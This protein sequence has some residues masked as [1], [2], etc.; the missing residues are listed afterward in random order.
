MN[1]AD[2]F[3]LDLKIDFRSALL[4]DY[5]LLEPDDPKLRQFGI[6]GNPRKILT[7][8][9]LHAQSKLGLDI[10]SAIVFYK[11]ANWRMDVAHVDV[12]KQ[13]PNGAVVCAINWIIG[14][15]GSNMIWYDK[16]NDARGD[17]V[18]DDMHLIPRAVYDVKNLIELHRA[19]VGNGKLTLVRTNIPHTIECGP[20][21][22]WCISMRA[23]YG[24]FK[25]WDKALEFFRDINL[26]ISSER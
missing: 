21:P 26:K 7:D 22:R 11:P 8:E 4:D 23:P 17:A 10:T 13:D 3:Y 6:Y 9:W 1:L 2:N 16:K 5:R 15:D 14:G 19:D 18:D 12:V 24:R 20:T 25:S